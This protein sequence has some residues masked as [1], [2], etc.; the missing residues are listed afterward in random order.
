VLFRSRP[1]G[2]AEDEYLLYRRLTGRLE[3]LVQ[4][5][6]AGH[7][8]PRGRVVELIGQLVGGVE[9]V[10]RGIDAADGRDGVEGNRVLG[11]IG[12]IDGEHVAFAEAP[13][14]EAGGRLPDR[15]GQ[16]AIGERAAARAVDQGW[17]VAQFQG[18]L[19]D[20]RGHGDIR[21]SHLGERTA[22]DH[23]LPPQISLS[24]RAGRWRSTRR[25]DARNDTPAAPP[26]PRQGASLPSTRAVLPRPECRGYRR[27]P[28][29]LAAP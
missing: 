1:R 4:A 6:R 10:D 5:L 17:L 26:A 12:A 11:Q 3:R 23:G 20:Q 24:A 9:G 15:V 14:R 22:E 28:F 2:L 25:A 29:R 8:V 13:P 27:E 19:Q 21:D 7:Q 16:L 18:A